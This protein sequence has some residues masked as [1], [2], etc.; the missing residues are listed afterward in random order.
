M[1]KILITGTSGFIGQ[2][3]CKTLLKSGRLVRATVR[4][5]NS[6]SANTE[7]EYVSL[8][9]ISHKTNWKDALV[10]IDCIIHCA[11]RAHIMNETKTDTL[12]I[13]RSVN[14]YG[15]K[16]LAEQAAEAKVKRLIFLSSVKVN[17][18]G[19]NNNYSDTIFI[20]FGER[21][22]SIFI[23]NKKV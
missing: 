17:G 21:T 12:K 11:G 18:E 13:Y 22:P 6:F 5:I 9:D 2:S 20:S 1:K 10:D 4:S 16:Q 19:T 14:V 8:G 7:I 15:T 23:T 3:L